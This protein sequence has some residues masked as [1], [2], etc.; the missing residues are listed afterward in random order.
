MLNGV[1][2]SALQ[3]ANQNLQGPTVVRQVGRYVAKC[4]RCKTLPHVSRVAGAAFRVL[5]VV[6]GNLLDNVLDTRIARQPAPC[7]APLAWRDG[8]R[9][10]C[11][12]GFVV[13]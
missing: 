5:A 9:L 1:F 6:R 7:F 4:F 2:L 11:Q 8:L 12:G 3:L 13:V 10:S